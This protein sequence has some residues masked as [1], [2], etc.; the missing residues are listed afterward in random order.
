MVFIIA[1]N[2][3]LVGLLGAA[4]TSSSG[5]GTVL[6]VV[7]GAVVAVIFFVLSLWLGGRRYFQLWPTWR[8][9]NPTGPQQEAAP[10][11]D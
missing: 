6:T 2:T 5:G 1:V 4:V 11:P 8:A 7:V 10:R 3:A 9:V